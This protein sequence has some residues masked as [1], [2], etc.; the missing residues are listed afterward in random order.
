M[1]WSI[2]KLHKIKDQPFLLTLGFERPHQPLFNPKR[3]H[4]MYPPTEVELPKTPADDLW[5][6]SPTSKA[7]RF[8]SKNLWQARN[9]GE[10]RT[11]GEC[12]SFLFG[13]S[14]ICGRACRR[15]CKSPRDLEAE[16]QHLDYTMVR[17]RLASR[18]KIPLGKGHWLVQKY[19]CTFLII[20]PV[21]STY[22]K[23]AIEIKNMVNLLDL[24]PTL[25]DIAGI[26]K[27]HLG[28]EGV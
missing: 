16:Q 15:S 22:Y 14:F 8:V 26:P 24:A 25:A 23:K 21:G 9:R 1:D 17:S 27:K 5:D 4:D 19:S 10:I 11:V 20:P 7:A 18:R 12:C 6:L 28:K 2:D 13:F 3:F